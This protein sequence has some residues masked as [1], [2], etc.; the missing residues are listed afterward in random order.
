MLILLSFPR[1][2][3]FSMSALVRFPRSKLMKSIQFVNSGFQ[4]FTRYDLILCYSS[5][6]ACR[7]PSHANHNQAYRPF[8]I[9]LSAIAFRL[10]LTLFITYTA[11]GAVEIA[12]IFSLYSDT[13]INVLAAPILILSKTNS[14]VNNST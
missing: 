8:S 5:S 3:T 12:N 2:G 1:V 9:F 13:T 6:G 10:P 7:P 4:S 11:R 14:F